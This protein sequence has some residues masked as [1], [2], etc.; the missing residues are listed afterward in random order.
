LHALPRA[1]Q[2]AAE[3]QNDRRLGQRNLFDAFGEEETTAAPAPANDTLPDVAA[4]PEAEKLK[5]EKE[6]LDF[7]LSSHPLA[8]LEKEVKRYASHSAV[9][10]KEA[11]ADKEV[12]VGGMLTQV[13]FKNTQKARNG[14][15]R[16]LLCYIEDFSGSMKCVMWPDDL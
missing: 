6:V 9:E 2:S 16:Y 7:Y 15:S 13:V 1:I 8:H 11:P 14:N 5:Y 4:W 12:T 3:R 10:A